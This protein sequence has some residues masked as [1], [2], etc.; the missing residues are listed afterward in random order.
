MDTVQKHSRRCRIIQWKS[1]NGAR[2]M[3]HSGIIT[4]SEAHTCPKEGRRR[5]CAGSVMLPLNFNWLEFVGLGGGVFKIPRARLAGVLCAG[6]EA[7]GHEGRMFDCVRDRRW[8]GRKGGERKAVQGHCE[9]QLELGSSQYQLTFFACKGC[10]TCI[11]RSK[12]TSWDM[13]I[14]V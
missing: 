3:S 13:H 14:C 5:V 1:G 11:R 12:V 2:Y 6:A 10:R 4:R 9:R 7:G 8:V